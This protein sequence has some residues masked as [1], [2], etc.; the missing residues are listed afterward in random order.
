MRSPPVDLRVD[1]GVLK[2]TQIGDFPV[3]SSLLLVEARFCC[4]DY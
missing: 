4:D 2:I 3:P 1:I